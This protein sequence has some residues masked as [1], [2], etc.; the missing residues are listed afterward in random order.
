M[1]PSFSQIFIFLSLTPSSVSLHE[2]LISR[3]SP[4]KRILQ[5][6][7]FSLLIRGPGGLVSQKKMQKKYRDTDTLRKPIKLLV[8]ITFSTVK[9]L[10]YMV[11]QLTRGKEK[12]LLNVVFQ[13]FLFL[14][15]R[16]C[17]LLTLMARIGRKALLPILL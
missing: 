13:Y 8:H 10:L 1:G 7:H 15:F 5:L 6:N 2:L 16:C 14:F 3:I 9:H 4:R 12:S 11:M 17:C